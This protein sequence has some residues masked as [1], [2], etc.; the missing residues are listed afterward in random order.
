MR[1]YTVLLMLLALFVSGTAGAQPVEQQQ[2][3]VVLPAGTLDA[4]QVTELFSGKTV[5]SVTAVRGRVSLSF[6]DV[7]GSLRQTRNDQTRSGKWR[8]R[9]DGRICL[10]MENFLEKCRI[11]VKDGDVYKKYIV[12]KN[13]R[14]QNSVNYRK[15]WVGNPFGL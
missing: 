12:K 15:F 1:Y 5:E 14:H 10:Q 11:I 3:T 8:V 9:K 4:E 6:Y 13:G 7:D 2:G